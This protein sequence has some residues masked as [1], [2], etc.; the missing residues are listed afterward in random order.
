MIT[1]IG[2]DLDDTLLHCDCYYQRAAKRYAEF[3]GPK[4]GI[5]PEQFFQEHYYPTQRRLIPQHGVGSDMMIM[6]AIQTA[7]DL[8]ES[9]QMPLNGSDLQ[10]LLKIGRDLF[11]SGFELL[12]GVREA[13]DYVRERYD[14]RLLITHG[15]LTEQERKLEM[16]DLDDLFTSIN[17]IGLK[18]VSAYRRILRRH[19]INPQNFLMVGNSVR[20]DIKPVLEIGGQAVL[21]PYESE[22]ALDVTDAETTVPRLNSLADLPE[23]LKQS[24]GLRSA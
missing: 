9:H 18:T 1:A 5:S 7:A 23:Y 16:H 17:I 19:G 10:N 14:Q 12:E 22:W 4:A 24:Q 15:H 13:L 11:Q 3:L 6:A 2:F 8:T 21:I 20:S